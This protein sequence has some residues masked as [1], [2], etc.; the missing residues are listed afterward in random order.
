MSHQ[1]EITPLTRIG[2]LLETYPELEQVLIECAPAFEKLRNPI[3]R[4]TVAKVATVQNAA[5]IAGID[6]RA[7][8]A[9]LRRAAGQSVDDTAASDPASTGDD[10]SRWARPPAWIDASKVAVIIDA[11]ALLET[12]EVPI[13][14]V[15][16]AAR[17]LG[18]DRVVLV[19]STFRPVPL[20]EALEQQGFRA[21]LRQAGP[22]RF[23][24]FI[25]RI[26]TGSSVGEGD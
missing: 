16:Q 6:A 11:D 18:G 14:R 12:G 2:E 3:L 4:R 8:V 13:G 23:E 5:S 7:M 15:A 26:A 9:K 10:A 17:S 24:T 25:G 21:F 22:D 20:I 1:L 19:T